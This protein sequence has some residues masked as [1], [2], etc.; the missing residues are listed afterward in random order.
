MG[1]YRITEHT[2]E[3]LLPWARKHLDAY[4]KRTGK[5]LPKDVADTFASHK[6]GL[7][8]T[9]GDSKPQTDAPRDG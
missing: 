3:L 8:G 4:L 2:G 5:T 9:T 1:G 6:G 7:M